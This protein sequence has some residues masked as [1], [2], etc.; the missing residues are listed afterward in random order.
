M[1]KFYR[2][3]WWCVIG[4]FLFLGAARAEAQSVTL[5]W[6]PNSEPDLAGYLIGYGTAPGQDHQLIDVGGSTSW[7]LYGFSPGTTYYFRVYAYSTSGLRST[8]SPDLFTTIGGGP[9][10]SSGGSSGCS[11]P[12]PFASLGGGSCS[13][14]QWLP[15]GFAPSTGSPSSPAPAPSGP[16]GTPDPFVALGGG[17]CSNGGWLPPGMIAPSILPAPPTPPPPP[18]AAPSTPFGCTTPDP[19]VSLGGGTCSRGGWL[20]PGMAAPA[21]GGGSSTP[22]GCTTPDPFV[23]LGGGTCING[24]W[25]PP[26]MAGTNCIT[27]DPFVSL[28]G[29]TCSNGGWLP[30]GLVPNSASFSAAPASKCPTADPFVNVAGLIGVCQKGGWVPVPGVNSTGTVRVFNLNETFWGIAGEDGRVYR[31]TSLESGIR[32]EGL[33]VSFKGTLGDQVMMPTAV[34]TVN[35]RSIAV[36]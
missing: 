23:S 36:R 25:R 32:V 1:L 24:G 6:D 3:G 15:P 34:T 5:A 18:P 33:R 20:P 9:S 4:A 2:V 10:G 7:T 26:G 22:G 11:T 19:F 16:C 35:L 14:G 27:P 8:P 21:G 12:D 31:P 17:T 29:G 28:G 13:N 30:P